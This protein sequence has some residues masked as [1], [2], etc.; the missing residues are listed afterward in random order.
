[1]ITP[2]N[3][4]D[5]GFPEL[6]DVSGLRSVAH[7]VKSPKNR[8]G[9]YLLAFSGDR[10][11]IGQAV[12]IVRR[13]SQHLKTYGEIDGF[14]YI[15]VAKTKL[16]AREKELI[17]N[18]EASGFTLLNVVHVSNIIGDTDL[19][20]LFDEGVLDRWLGDPELANLKDF[21]TQTIQLP[22]AH[23]ERAA[24]KFAQLK[25]H[26]LAKAAIIQ[27]ACFLE[28][29]VPYPRMSEFSFWTVTAMPGTNSST[30]PR[31]L[32]VS[33]SVMEV[34]GLGY[35]KGKEDADLTWSFVNVASD[36]LLESFG[37]EES[38]RSEYPSIYLDTETRYRDG[39]QYVFRLCAGTQN[40]M[41]QLLADIRVTK[42][43]ASLCLRLMRKRPTIF[44]KHHCPQ[45]VDAALV[46]RQ[47]S[48]Q[49]I[50]KEISSIL[51]D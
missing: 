36:F 16:D 15:Q 34:F 42:A 27:L 38:F 18:A 29:A 11:Y 31:I 13:F 30:M 23:N 39:G 2:K 5:L 50:D 47:W 28:V 33:T 6:T 45:L 17:F 51:L 22:K 41:I 25:R 26:P 14:T 9:I 49:A 43:A 4:A 48:D 8:C 10:Y 7:L 1:M 44:S 46:Y 35:Y 3:I 12:D 21:D 19:D 20:L 37:S 40:C 32:C 24:L